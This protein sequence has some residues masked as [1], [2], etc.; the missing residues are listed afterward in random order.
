MSSALKWK[1]FVQ[2]GYLAELARVFNNQQSAHALLEDVGFDRGRIPAWGDNVQPDVFWRGAAHEAEDGMVAGGLAALVRGAG[3]RYPHNQVFNPEA[4]SAPLERRA[5]TGPSIVVSGEGKVH[6]VIDG[7]RKIARRNGV[8]GPVEPG[9]ANAANV[10]MRLPEASPE[11]AREVAGELERQG[12]AERATAIANAVRDYLLER[13]YVEGPDQG[14]FELSD[15][16][17]S[18]RLKDVVRAVLDDYDDEIWPR[19]RSGASRPAVID[20]VEA[21]GSQTRLNPH[22]TVHESGL[23]DGDTVHVAPESTAGA[24]NPRRRDEALS[25][26]RSQILAYAAAHPGFRVRANANVAP[27]EYLFNFDA[28]GWGPPAGAG[29]APYP[30]DRHEVLL[31]RPADCPMLAPTAF[32]Q[33]QIFHPNVHRENG[34]VCLGVLEDRYRP[35]LDFGELCQILVDIAGYRNYEI[36]EGYDEEARNWAVSPEGQ[37]AIEERGGRS[38]TRLLLALLEDQVHEPFPLLVKRMD[39]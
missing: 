16:P 29:G 17:A 34:K 39:T 15:V 2:R 32:W 26:V 13:L 19:D 18:T 28:P 27:T 1:E 3:D 4:G 7:T 30:V 9:Y 8:P 35:G 20:R 38:V 24:V 5:E 33:T 6:P 22:E 36:R 11:Q 21:D 10:E 14:R 23:E 31:L 37:Q 12:L 25:R